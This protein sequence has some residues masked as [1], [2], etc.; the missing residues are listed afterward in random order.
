M[1]GHSAGVYSVALSPDGQY[2]ASGSWDN[3]VKLWRVESGECARTMEG[4]SY[5]VHSVS[6]SP[7][8]Q[9]LASGSCDN[10]TTRCE[11]LSIRRE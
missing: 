10:T 6:F 4:H 3:N 1:V 2:L 7:D 11:I 5:D 9:Y 8:G